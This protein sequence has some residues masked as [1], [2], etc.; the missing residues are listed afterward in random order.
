[1]AAESIRRCQIACPWSCF[2]L[3]P[4]DRGFPYSSARAELKAPL[5][6]EVAVHGKV[7]RT[8]V[9]L[10]PKPA[11]HEAAV[12]ASPGLPMSAQ[13]MVGLGIVKLVMISICEA[14]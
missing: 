9:Q 11:L 8:H 14:L 7:L 6:R 5:V 12:H 2:A 10:K 1:M 3:R 4:V 13:A